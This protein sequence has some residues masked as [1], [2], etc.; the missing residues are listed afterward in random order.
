METKS[1]K[2]LRPQPFALSPL[3]VIV[4]ETASGKSRLAI[5]LALKYGGEI[6]S[7]DSWAVRKELNIGTAKPTKDEQVKVSHHLIDV[8][9]PCQDFTAAVFK[10]LANRAITNINSRGKLPIMAGGSG[11]YID[12]VIFDFSFLKAGNRGQRQALN[13][14]SQPQLLAKVRVAGYS[15][16]GID[17]RNK[18]RLIR[19]LETGGQRPTNKNLRPN[20][21]VI[22]LQAQRDD[23]KDR[24]KQRVENMFA[25]GL[26]NEVK[27]LSEKY[28]W[29]CEGLK[30][31]GYIEWREYFSGTQT[32]DQIKQKIIK[33]TLDLAKRQRTWFKR[34]ESIQWI[35]DPKKTDEIVTT[36]L[37]KKSE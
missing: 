36:F 4:G 17:I 28:G 29:D 19:L 1:I 31:I 10:K 21:L 9:E 11:L 26:E 3:L 22:G 33:N 6:I 27:K 12:G 23:L 24:V 18:R 32:L 34:N 2:I 13:Q 37:N 16:E 35:D 7:A 8:V 5:D 15:L 25:Q 14:L 30:G 20:T